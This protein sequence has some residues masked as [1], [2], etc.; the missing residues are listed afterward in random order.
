MIS[1]QDSS[2]ITAAESH[3]LCEGHV[4]T[5]SGN[6]E[7]ESFEG[8]FFCLPPVGRVSPIKREY[9]SVN[10][11]AQRPVRPNKPER[12]GLGQRKVNYRVRQGDWVAHA[13]KSPEL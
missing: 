12:R 13:L 9:V 10:F 7:V 11:C 4:F 2:L 5:G 1:S 6:K 3:L 8:L